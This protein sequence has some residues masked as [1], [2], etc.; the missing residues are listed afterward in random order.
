MH[1]SFLFMYQESL[2]APHLNML[3][4]LWGHE[5]FSKNLVGSRKF[6]RNFSGVIKFFWI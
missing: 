2:G 6:I 4:I 5:I 3:I 1:I